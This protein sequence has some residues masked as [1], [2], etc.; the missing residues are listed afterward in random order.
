MA[1]L[2]QFLASG[3][4]GAESGSA[5]FVLR[6]TASSAASVMWNEF[7][8]LTQPATNI[9]T[10][11]ANGAAEV[12]VSA[13]CDVEL[14][15]SAG[16]TLRTVTIGNSDSLTEVQSASFTG[17]DYDGNPANTVGHPITLQ[18][19]LDKWIESAGAADWKILSGGAEFT[20][21]AAF[22]AVSGILFINVQHPD[23]GATGDG[24]TD[25]TSAILAAIAAANGGIVFFPPGTYK[26]TTLTL[27]G[28][29]VNIM[30]SG[31][32]VSIISGTT[33]SELIVVADNTA[34]GW[35]NFRGL[36]LTCSGSYEQLVALEQNQNVTFSGCVFDGTNVSSDIIEIA[37]NTGLARYF[38]TDCAFSL[39]DGNIR[40][41][42]NL[43]ASNEREI[44]V[45]GC[46]FIMADDY[47]GD[48]I[49]GADF[50]VS[51]CTFDA[52]AV[53]SGEYHAVYPED[54]SVAGKFVGTFTGNRFLDG[55]SDGYAFYLPG[56][57]TGS[58]FIEN[59]NTFS[60]FVEPT[61]SGDSGQV[62]FISYH[63]DHDESTLSLGSRIGKTRYL[64]K[65]DNA[66]D[67]YLVDAVLV[68]EK[69]II[70]N[71]YGGG[72][73]TFAIDPEALP[74]GASATLIV[75]NQSGTDN[76]TYVFNNRPGIAQATIA[77]VDDD[78]A[79]IGTYEGALVTTGVERTL[80]NTLVA[81]PL[82]PAP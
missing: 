75:I 42:N 64:T 74:P 82:P 78:Y 27:T 70:Y 9:V 80:F 57:K 25:D 50:N 73:S 23:F 7:E 41:I 2:V 38:I 8:E 1:T 20:L 33:A 37:G 15:T 67:P 32:G 45:K 71:D 24:T 59:G 76:L 61:G 4:R 40:A 69:V 68:A 21:A 62:Y 26:V 35:K 6:G 16:V 3:V 43:A 54:A 48:C 77:N 18:A 29:N 79:V 72:T 53:T 65:A 49:L 10:L 13:Y 66:D 22:A 63:A 58:V 55:G 51:G 17:T 31:Q 60:G 52:S 47:S 56:I 46:S 28:V 19:V 44:S 11:D 81:N 14:K 39:P 34:S 12:Y 5:T 30:G 36:T